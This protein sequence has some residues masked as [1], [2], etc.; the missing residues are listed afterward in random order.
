MK[1]LL[2]ATI[3][4]YGGV[5]CGCFLMWRTTVHRTFRAVSVQT[6]VY[7]DFAVCP[8]C[9]R[10]FAEPRFKSALHEARYSVWRKH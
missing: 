5:L 10:P 8:T 2:I 9:H 3:A 1:I 4:F 7:G 6:S